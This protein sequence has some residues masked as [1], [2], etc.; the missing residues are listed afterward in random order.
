MVPILGIERFP[1]LALHGLIIGG[2][3]WLVR[4]ALGRES[5]AIALGGLIGAAVGIVVGEG[6]ALQLYQAL[7]TQGIKGA[8]PSGACLYLELCVVF[9]GA[10]VGGILGGRPAAQRFAGGGQAVP[11]QNR[12]SSR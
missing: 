3:V 10:V 2:F 9:A 6:Y 8:S 1:L 12:T 11:S 5:G 4:W 7:E